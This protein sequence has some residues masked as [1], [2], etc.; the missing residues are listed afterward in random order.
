MNKGL[1]LVT[2]WTTSSNYK[3]EYGR[4][5]GGKDYT[6]MDD[7]SYYDFHWKQTGGK[8]HPYVAEKTKIILDIIP[9]D[10]RT[11]IDIGCG[12]GSITNVLTERYTVVGGDISQEGLKNLSAKAQPTICSADYLPFKDKCAD[13]VLSSELLEHLPNSVF[14]RTIS[15]IKRITGKYILVT[16]PNNENLRKRYTKCNAC[17]FE[18][19]IYRHLRSFNLNKLARYFDGYIIRCSTL[20]GAPDNKSFDMISY[21]RNKLANSYFFVDTVL[22]LCPNCGETTSPFRANLTCRLIGFS[23][24][25]LQN[26]LSLSLNRK[27][28]LDWLVALF[29]KS[30]ETQGEGEP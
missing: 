29:K 15:E 19:H 26:I 14:L 7:K 22:I 23:L 8:E 1:I 16:V 25:V 21:L 27:P 6:V 11:V 10:V 5:G 2:G 9:Q 20:C 12:D 24:L 13:L 3:T 17:G 4:I 28:E 30:E 18:F